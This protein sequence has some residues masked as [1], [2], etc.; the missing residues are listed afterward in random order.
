M[1]AFWTAALA[2]LLLS[3]ACVPVSTH[4]L[5]DPKTA[6]LIPGLAGAW[7]AIIEGEQAILHVL[8]RNDRLAELL[9]VSLRDARDTARGDWMAFTLFPSR[10]GGDD[11]AN[12]RFVGQSG[13]GEPDLPEGYIFARFRLAA[14]DTL[15]IWTMRAEAAREA[16]EG[17]LQG[18]VKEAKWVD[19]I[20]FTA[21]TAILRAYLEKHG[22]VALFKEHLGSFR[23]WKRP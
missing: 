14:D 10:I 7:R 5:S 4:P 11:Y 13:E 22:P 18:E 20:R 9:V 12:L 16:I 2:V 1:R 17:G 6:R 19:E 3:A 23:R 8:P 21:S 15:D